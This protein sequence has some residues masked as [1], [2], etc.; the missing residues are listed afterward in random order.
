[1]PSKKFKSNRDI[2]V[3]DD[4][5]NFYDYNYIDSKLYDLLKNHKSNLGAIH[6]KS[7]IYASSNNKILYKYIKLG[8]KHYFI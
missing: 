2:S 4:G 1:M 6:M 8:L 7:Y 3:N 5:K